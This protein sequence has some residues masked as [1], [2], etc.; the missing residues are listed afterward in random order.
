MPTEEKKVN[1]ERMRI[2]RETSSVHSVETVTIPPQS[3]QM[4]NIFTPYS[5][6][7]SKIGLLETSTHLGNRLAITLGII[8][9]DVN[10]K[11]IQVMI[12]QDEPVMLY[13]HARL[14]TFEA[15]NIEPTKDTVSCRHISGGDSKD[16]LVI[17]DHLGD[18]YN[19]RIQ[20]LWPA[21]K[22]SYTPVEPR[23]LSELDACSLT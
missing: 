14:A 17:P 6:N 13:P 11:D 5:K 12:Y 7:C 4:I 18:L 9:M 15:V 1:Y 19:R 3:I 22:T 8:N 21:N 10:P 23:C 2:Y 16:K 20:Q